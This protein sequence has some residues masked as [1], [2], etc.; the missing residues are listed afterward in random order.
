[1]GYCW[2]RGHKE[3][4][5]WKF[6]ECDGRSST[7]TA[8]SAKGKPYAHMSRNRECPEYAQTRKE[9]IEIAEDVL[10]READ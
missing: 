10:N 6:P 9:A 5:E 2:N 7:C 3:D 4:G 1:M 8:D